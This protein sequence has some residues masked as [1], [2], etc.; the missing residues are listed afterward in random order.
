[1]IKQRHS[2]DCGVACLA[3]FLDVD[4]DSISFLCKKFFN[5]S[6]SKVGMNIEQI[7]IIMKYGFNI[8]PYVI[9]TLVP[10]VP[11]ITCVPSLGQKKHFHYIYIDEEQIYDPSNHETYKDIDEHFAVSES[12]V[13]KNLFD[14]EVEKNGWP[15]P[16]H[17]V[18]E[19]DWD[20]IEQTYGL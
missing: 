18:S 2:Q 11:S 1:M 15:K 9:R 5:E 13:F 8:E 6:F 10:T 16:S 19:F 3:M 17:I 20:Y 12:I 4:Y 14:L 7:A